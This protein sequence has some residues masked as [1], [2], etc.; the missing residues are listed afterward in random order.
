MKLKHLI[1]AGGAAALS[2][3]AVKNRNEII[4][5][6][7]ETAALTKQTKEDYQAVQD[8]IERLKAYQEPVANLL[9][10]FQYKLRTYQQSIAGN[11]EEIEKFQEKYSSEEE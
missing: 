3:W 8:N 9:K 11:I 7:K 5:E 6:T 2:Y 1:L 10:D 4:A